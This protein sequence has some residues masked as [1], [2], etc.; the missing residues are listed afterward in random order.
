MAFDVEVCVDHILEALGR[1]GQ[2]V[3]DGKLHVVLEHLLAVPV[4][5]RGACVEP[6]KGALSKLGAI[7][8]ADILSSTVPGI[9]LV[10]QVL[11]TINAPAIMK[12]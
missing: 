1:I 3:E 4:A 6:N 2:L 8:N 12:G 10:M 7:L 5:L 9:F 11:L